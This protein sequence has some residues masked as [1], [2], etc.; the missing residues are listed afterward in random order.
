VGGFSNCGRVPL[1]N[2]LG[3]RRQQPGELFQENCHELFEEFRIVAGL[4][5][6]GRA[7]KY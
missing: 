6:A 1:I 3:Q 2:G 7:V 5:E 4:V